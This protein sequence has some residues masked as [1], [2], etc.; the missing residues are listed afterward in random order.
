M[1]HW[2]VTLVIALV[3]IAGCFLRLANARARERAGL[4]SPV[5]VKLPLHWCLF[6]F[7]LIEAGIA[8]VFYTVP[9]HGSSVDGRFWFLLVVN[10]AAIVVISFRLITRRSPTVDKLTQMEHRNGFSMLIGIAGALI[11]ACLSSFLITGQW[12]YP[13]KTPPADA[14]YIFGF[15]VLSCSICVFASKN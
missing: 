8:F 5:R 10:T 11:G 15:A 12:F 7:L 6:L 4:P 14:R 2:V 3:G 13:S 9:S 1:A